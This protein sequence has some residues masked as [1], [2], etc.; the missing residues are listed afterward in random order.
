MATQN[1]QKEMAQ[2]K[3]VFRRMH[4]EMPYSVHLVPHRSGPGYRRFGT[5]GSSIVKP[6]DSRPIESALKVSRLALLSAT[7]FP[8]NSSPCFLTLYFDRGRPSRRPLPRVSLP[9][10]SAHHHIPGA[11]PDLDLGHRIVEM[12][13]IAEFMNGLPCYDE[14]NFSSSILS[15]LSVIVT[16]F[17]KPPYEQHYSTDVSSTTDGFPQEHIV[18]TY[19]VPPVN[20]KSPPLG[21]WA[22]QPQGEGAGDRPV[23]TYDEVS[24]GIGGDL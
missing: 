22:G 3:E 19:L 16:A 15:D 24:L 20:L 14:N 4:G 17:W 18:L 6:V 13:L 10:Q 2:G 11:S 23:K 8:I 5:P 9:F 7:H 1:Y 12:S 21:L